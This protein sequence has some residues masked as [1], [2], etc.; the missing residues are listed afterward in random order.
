MVL[1]PTTLGRRLR[2]ARENR[3]LTQEQAAQ[4]I[5][6]SR[7]ALVHIE[8]GKRSLS[9]LEL[10]GLARLYHRSV[11]DFFAEDES[12][13][14]REDDP[15]L[16]LHRLPPELLNNPEVNR[17]VSRCVELCSIGVQLAATLGLEDAANLPVYE[18]RAP[19]RPPEATR[20][21]E[22][23]A[24]DE[25]RRLGLGYGPI[26]DMADLI[27]T[28]GIRA[29]GV[30]GLPDDISGIFLRHSSIGLVI[31][32]NY[33]H[34]RARKRFS[35]AH[36]YAHAL[37]DRKTTSAIVS[38]EENRQEF[39][40]RRANAFAAALLMPE[41][42]VRWFMELLEKG[43][44]S[45]RQRITYSSA[46]NEPVE[47]EERPAPGSQQITYQDVVALANHF[48]VSYPAATY[49]LSDLGFL[50]APEKEALL[51]RSSLGARLL[52]VMDDFDCDQDGQPRR[53]PDRELVSQIIRLAVEAYRREEVSQGW[54]RDL[55]E[56]LDLPAKE[57]VEMAEAA[58]ES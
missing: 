22:R 57:L 8:S 20:Q 36:E 31:L 38:R 51:L 52:D 6:L 30:M 40:E 23:V 37:L 54:I 58:A 29:S 47:A 34:A 7:T 43:S 42:G 56:K 9:T 26:A 32:V 50:N 53:M 11:T 27:G 14:S 3:R 13:A 12:Q 48:G 46:G 21:G 28:Q 16:I 55:S 2:E 19:S 24:E 49:R 41:T 4:A 39:I 17:Q 5:D 45:R 44:P 1:D 10:S 15:L 35:Y 18:Y 33:D 25:R